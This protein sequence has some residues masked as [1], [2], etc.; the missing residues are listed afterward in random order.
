MDTLVEIS[1]GLK[2][3]L[4]DYNVLDLDGVT[5]PGVEVE[6][7]ATISAN[8]FAADSVTFSTLAGTYLE[9]AAHLVT[10]ARTIDDVAIEEMIVRARLMRLPRVGPRGLIRVEDLERADP[11][12]EDGEALIIDTGWGSYWDRN[13]YVVDAPA[14]AASTLDWLIAQP[15]SILAV[16]TPVMECRWAAAEGVEAEAGPLLEPLYKRK[17]GMLLLAPVVNLDRITGD[18]GT[19]LALPANVK[20]VPS[21][22]CRAL[23]V[24]DERWARDVAHAAR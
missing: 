11:E 17:R 12:L 20:G 9:T 13:G 16:D 24:A 18:R 21:S 4:W 2:P 5:L 19:L 6:P 8:G 22:P 14:F 7:A 10:G 15:F 3:G 1:G 23:F